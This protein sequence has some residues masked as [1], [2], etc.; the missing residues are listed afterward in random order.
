ML[1]GIGRYEQAGWNVDGPL[2]VVSDVARWLLALKDVTLQL[3]LFV[4]KDASLHDD[5][6]KATDLKRLRVHRDTSATEL[7]RFAREQLPVDAPPGAH[8]FFFWSGHGMTCDTSDHRVYACG[9]YRDGRVDA[10]FNASNFV[11][12]LRTS[13]FSAFS[14]QIV[15]ADVCGV[16]RHQASVTLEPLKQVKRPQVVRFASLAGDTAKAAAAGG[17]FAKTVLAVLSAAPGYPHDLAKL[18]DDFHAAGLRADPQTI[19]DAA[20]LSGNASRGA[21]LES[22]WKLLDGQDAHA[23]F[24]HHYERTVADLGLPAKAHDLAS[25]LQDLCE[26][27]DEKGPVPHGLMQ[28]M[29]RLAT[30]PTL[31]APVAEWL[32]VEARSQPYS[33]REIT[34]KLA[35]EA[36]QRLLLVE[37]RQEAGEITGLRPYLC[38]TD[39]SFDLAHPFGETVVRGWQAFESA[40]QAVLAEVAPHYPIDEMQIQFM[41]DLPL[42]D[43]PFHRIPTPDGRPLGQQARVVLRDRGRVLSTNPKTLKKWADYAS[44]LRGQNPGEVRWIRVDD[45]PNIPDGQGLCFAAFSLPHPVEGVPPGRGKEVLRRVL[46]LGTPFLYVRHQPPRTPGDWGDVARALQLL[47]AGLGSIED[48]VERFHDARLRGDED[49]QQASLVWDDPSFNPFTNVHGR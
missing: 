22:A 37:V 17:T 1:V 4:D 13:A 42:L 20:G 7:N 35:R 9:D 39:I 15:L 8:L 11:R 43:R 16:Y 27:R 29:M 28:F 41:I 36:L 48:F 40:M 49:A 3:D 44:G 46:N 31:T 21:L 32:D 19:A 5:I 10:F 47:S 23:L 18:E 12:Y 24:A 33:R 2:A 25:A 34:D 38:R 45:G 14:K 30:V 6:V 26:M